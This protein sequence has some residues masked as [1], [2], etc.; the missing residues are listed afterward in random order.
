MLQAAGGQPAQARRVGI[1]AGEGGRG[2]APV[3]LVGSALGYLDA[4]GRGGFREG[5]GPGGEADEGGARRSAPGGRGEGGQGRRERRD[6][7]ARQE[8]GDV[9][10]GQDWEEGE[11]GV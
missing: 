9:G 10:R 11:S 2:G 3:L 7:G 5:G 4:Q 1:H 8:E 6:E